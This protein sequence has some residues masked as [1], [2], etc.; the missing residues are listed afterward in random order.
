MSVAP[1]WLCALWDQ[2]SV[3][4]VVQSSDFGADWCAC[5]AALH[6]VLCLPQAEELGVS[7][8]ALGIPVGSDDDDG[9][10]NSWRSGLPSC[11]PAPVAQGPTSTSGSGSAGVRGSSSGSTSLRRSGR[12]RDS[13]HGNSNSTAAIP[14]QSPAAAAS[15]AG[16][17]GAVG[18]CV[19]LNYRSFVCLV[20][21]LI[22]ASHLSVTASH[23]YSPH[24]Y[25][26]FLRIA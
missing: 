17:V 23:K 20:G 25:A 13:I 1:L 26:L 6:R 19:P 15:G 10:V 16:G 4:S 2:H 7:P 12:I 11:S 21:C 9:D 8:E 22:I 24:M 5:G 18:V 14:A 3:A